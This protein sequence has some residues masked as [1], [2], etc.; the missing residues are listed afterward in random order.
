MAYGKSKWS[1]ENGCVLRRIKR[2]RQRTG[3]NVP[4][5]GGYR[6]MRQISGNYRAHFNQST[7]QAWNTRGHPRLLRIIVGRMI[8]SQGSRGWKP[9]AP[10][11]GERASDRSSNTA[12]SHICHPYP[13]FALY[14][15][16]FSVQLRVNLSRSPP[17]FHLSKH[18]RTRYLRIFPRFSTRAYQLDPIDSSERKKKR[19]KI[20]GF[21][22]IKRQLVEMVNRAAMNV[23][24]WKGRRKGEMMV[25]EVE[26]V[27]V[28]SANDFVTSR[29]A[30]GSFI[31]KI[32]TRIPPPSCS[33]TRII[34]TARVNESN[35]I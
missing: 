31:P 18:S 35:C 3:P 24:C 1:V 34:A 28:G 19:I 26:T 9:I 13:V 4:H 14:L 22:V 16:N 2:Y 25:F 32:F 12:K 23:E 15:L 11:S 29:L 10:F 8:I 27:L 33:V 5:H 21:T 17:F 7:W 6:C 30:R 20:I